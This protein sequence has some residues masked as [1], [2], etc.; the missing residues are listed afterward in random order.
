MGGMIC[1]FSSLGMD[2]YVADSNWYF[3]D[4]RFRDNPCLY[5]A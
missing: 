3:R 1:V 2:R 4:S 5:K